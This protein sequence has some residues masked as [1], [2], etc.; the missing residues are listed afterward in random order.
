MT[1]RSFHR[2][3]PARYA[4]DRRALLKECGIQSRDVV[5]VID[6]RGGAAYPGSVE[7]GLANRF[8]HLDDAAR[9]RAVEKALGDRVIVRTACGVLRPE[10]GRLG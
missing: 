9:Q 1:S 2:E 7:M 5:S 8:P 3:P 4:P 6:A 10:R